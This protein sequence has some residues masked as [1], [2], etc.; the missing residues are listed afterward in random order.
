MTD[1]DFSACDAIPSHAVRYFKIM[2]RF[3]Y[4]LKAIG[5]A[6]TKGDTIEICWDRLANEH[7]GRVRF[8]AIKDGGKAQTLI[9]NPPSRQV[10]NVDGSLEFRPVGK[11][12][13]AQELLGA[14]R[15]VRNNLFHGGKSGDVDHE[16]N[17][18]L[19]E[20]ATYVI[21]EMLAADANLRTAFEGKY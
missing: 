3:E 20:E 16:R 11:V 21:T 8:K 10:I 1:I 6:K 2:M 12:M 19:I 7:L 9:N 18:A 15:R 13:S 5:L 4:A 17:D 14:V